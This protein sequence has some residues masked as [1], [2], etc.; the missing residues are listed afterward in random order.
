METECREGR[1]VCLANN[2][3]GSFAHFSIMTGKKKRAK[4]DQMPGVC[5]GYKPKQDV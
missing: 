3:G 4:W 5:L 1:L 2:V